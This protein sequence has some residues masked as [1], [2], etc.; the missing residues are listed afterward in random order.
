MFDRGICLCIDSV[1]LEVKGLASYF[2]LKVLLVYR[3]HCITILVPAGGSVY[4]NGRVEY[5][6]FC[7]SID[8]RCHFVTFCLTKETSQ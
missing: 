4:S 3:Y 6:C 5:I 1:M 7:T 2:N 8:S